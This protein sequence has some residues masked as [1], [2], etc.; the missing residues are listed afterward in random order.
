MAEY[1]VGID[2]GGTKI[3]TARCDLEGT[4]LA[5][6]RELTLADEGL[7]A[8]M[9]RLLH[10]VDQVLADADP[11][12]LLG[13]GVGAP[14]PLDPQTGVLYGP[15]NLP[16]WEEVHLSAILGRHLK[17]RLGRTVRVQAG[18]DAN[19]AALGEFRFGVG[20]NYFGLRHM[21][22]MTVST[23]IGGGVIAGGK[24]YE[25]ATGMAAEIGHV[26]VD[27]NGPRC[28]CGNIGCIE[29]IAAGPAIDRQ[30]GELVAAGKAHILSRLVAGEPEAVTTRLVEAAAREGDPDALALIERTGVALG[31][32]VVNCL[33]S[34]NPQ[35]VVIGGGVAKMGAL[36]LDPMLATVR[37]R[38]M[39]AIL[40]GV[41]IV[42]AALGDRVGV[43]GAAALILQD[44]L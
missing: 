11:A 31:V 25:G 3:L 1:V 8:V 27:M 19:A 7:D 26:S 32:A 14:G 17:T 20:R 22:Y 12:G 34:Y 39:P 35:L 33:H 23:G 36:L 9:G 44:R 30:G 40:R 43:L 4:V 29:A 21:V 5:Q 10:T 28:N 42:P 15:P 38:A 24:I 13:V 2:L 41:D 16:G 6:T 37:A 18:N